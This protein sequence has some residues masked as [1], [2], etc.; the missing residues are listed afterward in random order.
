M[1]KEHA[2]GCRA[3]EDEHGPGL[4]EQERGDRQA[5][6]RQDRGHRGVAGERE[7]HEPDDDPD[8]PNERREPEERTAAGRDRLPALREAE[9]DRAPVA[10]HRRA[11]GER[12]GDM[13][14]RHRRDERRDE[15]LEDV[16]Q[17]HRNRVA[18]AR[19]RA[20]RSSPRCC[21]C[22]PCG[23]PRR[24]PAGDPVPEREAAGEVADDDEGERLDRRLLQ[25]NPVLRDPVVH[26]RPVEVVEEDVDVGSPVG[27]VVE[28]VRVLVDVE[29]HQ[30]RRVP[31]R[32]T[33]SAHRRCS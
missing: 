21:R 5:T 10:E 19:P 30:G 15:P 25:R 7:H 24:G 17:H 4:A 18:R 11:A 3:R 29:R 31:D 2:D 14:D 23:C 33:C 9:E 6:A 20:R 27:A 22:R 1:Q 16:E 32:D 12:T 13:P 26:G 8:Q 28:E